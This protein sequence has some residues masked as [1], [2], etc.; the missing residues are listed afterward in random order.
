MTIIH[1]PQFGENDPEIAE[2]LL[3]ESI[4]DVDAEV[5][6]VMYDGEGKRHVIGTATISGREVST[7]L[8][9]GPLAE[10]VMDAIVGRPEDCHFSIGFKNPP[11]RY[12]PDTSKHIKFAQEYF[13]KEK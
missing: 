9:D 6:L 8:N 5:P 4:L 13:T 2:V 7:R 3:H 10:E 1:I 12:G 11:F